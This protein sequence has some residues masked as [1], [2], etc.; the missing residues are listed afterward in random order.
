VRVLVDDVNSSQVHCNLVGWDRTDATDVLRHHQV[1]LQRADGL[2]ING[3]EGAPLH[4][5][6]GHRGLDTGA[7][8]LFN[9]ERGMRHDW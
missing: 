3:I 6:K 8:L 1:G 4:G 9:P 5:G 7:V 2:G